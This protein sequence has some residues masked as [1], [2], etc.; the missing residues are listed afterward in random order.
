MISECT[1][2]RYLQVL[3]LKDTTLKHIKIECFRGRS[4]RSEV[5]AF[6]LHVA[7]P[8]RTWNRSPVS[9]MVPK[10]RSGI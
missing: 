6:A 7:E 1:T 2:A 5:D 9:Q 4:E 3:Q 10:A 8:E